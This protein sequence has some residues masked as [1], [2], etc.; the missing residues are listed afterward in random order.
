LTADG[1]SDAGE[2]RQ[3]HIGFGNDGLKIDA[4]GVWTLPWRSVDAAQPRL[5][6]PAYGH[7][8]FDVNC[9]PGA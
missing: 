1:S 6:H 8:F 4:L 7:R 9:P 5:S 3:A 2:W